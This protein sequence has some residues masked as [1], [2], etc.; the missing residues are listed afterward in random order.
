MN[1]TKSISNINTNH[2]VPS[3]VLNSTELTISPLAENLSTIPQ[4]DIIEE[5]TF[6]STSIDVSNNDDDNDGIL[7]S[8][9]NNIWDSFLDFLDEVINAENV[10]VISTEKTTTTLVP[11]EVTSLK[12]EEQQGRNYGKRARSSYTFYFLVHL[13]TRILGLLIFV[14][15][16][17][18][19]VKA[20]TNAM[21]G[22]KS[23][24][25]L[26]SSPSV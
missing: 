26:S 7:L 19:I 6:S 20:F 17:I 3:N 16:I 9:G 18:I 1:T 2:T 15:I 23:V 14:M 4:N 5:N 24:G 25:P 8:S 10:T 21:I 13:L 22:A 11:R 12:F